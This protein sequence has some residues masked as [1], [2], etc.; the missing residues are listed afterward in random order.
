HD[1]GRAARAVGEG[2]RDDGGVAGVASAPAGLDR[3]AGAALRLLPERDDDPGRRSSVDDEESDRG[4]DPHGDE[5]PSLPLWHLSAHPDGDQAG[6]RRDGEGREVTMTG[7]LHEKEFW[8]KNF[9]K[10]SGAVVVGASVVGAGLAG[11]ASAAARPTLAGY[12]A[13]ATQIDS[14][15]VVNADNTIILRQTKMETG[16]GITTG[17]LQVV[18]EEL[19]TDIKLMRYGPSLYNSEGAM[20]SRV[21]TWDAVNTGGEGGSNAMSG[22]GPQIRAAAAAARIHLLNLASQQLG[23]PVSQLSVDKGVVSGGGKTVTYGALLGGKT[24]GKTLASLGVPSTLNPGVSPAKAIANYRTVT[25]RDT[26]LRLDIPAKVNGVYT[27]VHNIRVPG[28]LHGRVIRPH[29]QGAYPYNS[30]VAVSVDEKSISH[31][32]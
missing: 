23:V 2:A 20:N 14:W 13:D 18:A 15:F 5:R 10:G 27:Y 26:V 29:G 28:M 24:F 32:P 19:D 22:T 7:F 31:I 3:C 30:N 21:D 17:F 16:N 1:V 12:N 8:R 11:K 6:R 4:S 25:K 9:L